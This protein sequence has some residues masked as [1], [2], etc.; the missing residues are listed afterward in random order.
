MKRMQI[1]DVIEDLKALYTKI[2]PRV[3]RNGGLTEKEIEE[4]V[5]THRTRKTR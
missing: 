2:E 5:Q 4:I 3:A 1:H